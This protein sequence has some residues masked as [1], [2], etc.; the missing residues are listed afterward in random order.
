MFLGGCSGGSQSRPMPCSSTWKSIATL[1]SSLGVS[2]QAVDGALYDAFGQR[3]VA[4]MYTQLNQYRV[5]L[6]AEPEAGRAAWR[7]RQHVRALAR[8]GT[9]SRLPRFPTGRLRAP[10]CP[11]AIKGSFLRSRCRSTWRRKSRSVRRL[12]PSMAPRH[13]SGCPRVWW[14]PRKAT[15]Q[16]LCGFSVEPANPDLAALLAVYIVLGVLYES[17]VHPVTILPPCLGGRGR[18]AGP[19][20]HA[21]EFRHHCADWRD[22]AHRHREE[23]RHHDES[24]SRCRPSASRA[25]PP[26]TPSSTPVCCDFDPS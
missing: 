26:A 9:D 11:S 14:L 2:L 18:L 24:T 16:G 10:H 23:E 8:R 21:H 15:G 17:L 6:E 5:V 22:P 3:Q 13:A 25:C 1:P 12:M 4:T 20:A 7:A 19:H